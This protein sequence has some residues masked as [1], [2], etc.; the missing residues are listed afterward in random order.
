METITFNAQTSQEM[1]WLWAGILLIALAGGGLFW[2]FQKRATS[3]RGPEKALIQMLLFFALL[4]GV[5]TATFSGIAMLRLRPLVVHSTGIE[6][7]GVRTP[8]VSLRQVYVV[9]T[10]DKTFLNTAGAQ[11][12]MLVIERAGYPDLF[13]SES[14]YPISEM[15]GVIRDKSGK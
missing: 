7:H 3:A 12:R 8:W 15:L 2:S 11:S 14:S 6:Y 10:Q 1:Q 5:G 4:I 13:F 9:S